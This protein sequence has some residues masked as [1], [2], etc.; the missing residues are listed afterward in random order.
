[1]EAVGFM[2]RLASASLVITGEGS[3][4]AGSLHGKVPA[5]V[6]EEAGLAR[7]PVAILC[8]VASADAPG[9]FVRSLVDLVG[10]DVA[11]TDPRG[12]LERLAETLAGDEALPGKV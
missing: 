10:P 4:D 11:L 5:G 1:M 3:F 12:A 9:A 7:V 8:G 2:D 6:L